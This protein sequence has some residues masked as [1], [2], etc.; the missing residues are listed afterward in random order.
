MFFF[1]LF[2]NRDEGELIFKII[3]TTETGIK[4]G[5]QSAEAALMVDSEDPLQEVDSAIPGV[6]Q[7]AEAVREEASPD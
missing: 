1:I 4:D 5:H 2:L 7:E 3:C 6:F